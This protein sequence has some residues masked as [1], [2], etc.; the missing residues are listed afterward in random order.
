MVTIIIVV[1]IIVIVVVSIVINMIMSVG[2]KQLL[3]KIDTN[4]YVHRPTIGKSRAPSGCV[5]FN[6]IW[7]FSWMCLVGCSWWF[8]TLYHGI[9]HHEKPPFGE[10]FPSI[11]EANQSLVSNH[12]RLH[13]PMLNWVVVSNIFDDH[14]YLGKWSNLTNIFFQMGWFNH[15]LIVNTRVLNGAWLHAAAGCSGMFPQQRGGIETWKPDMWTLSEFDLTP[16]FTYSCWYM[17]VYFCLRELGLVLFSAFWCMVYHLHSCYPPE[18][19]ME[20]GKMVVGRLFSFC[21]GL[22][23]QGLLGTTGYYN[24][25]LSGTGTTSTCQKHHWQQLTLAALTLKIPHRFASSE[26]ATS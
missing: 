21:T 14:P 2:L 11:E 23:L 6:F 17:L 10:L 8:F 4:L 18:S 7:I 26:S 5:L 15:Q 19:N 16:K 9:H 3:Y 24:F 12:R 25:F 20:P 13:K 22:Y 1:V